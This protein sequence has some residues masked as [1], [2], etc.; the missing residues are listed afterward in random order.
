MALEAQDYL[1]IH[2]YSLGPLQAPQKRGQFSFVGNQFNDIVKY[3][4]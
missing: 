3:F 4:K 2:H 1:T